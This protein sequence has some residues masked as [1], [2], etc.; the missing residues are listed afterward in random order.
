MEMPG[1]Q[2]QLEFPFSWMMNL[3]R[4]GL[5]AVLL[6]WVHAQFV[7]SDSTEKGLHET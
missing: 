4:C 7:I 3:W 2:G 6:S 5:L 1:V